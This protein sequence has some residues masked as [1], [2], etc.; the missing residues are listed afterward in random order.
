M[1]R[2]QFLKLMGEHYDSLK[3][4]KG[5]KS[6]YSFEKKFEELWLGAGREVMEKVIS[7]PG[8]NRRKKKH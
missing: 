6:F 3:G 7:E 8:T 5:E 1:E 4:L 2:E